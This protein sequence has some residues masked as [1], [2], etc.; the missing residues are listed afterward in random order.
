MGSYFCFNNV[1]VVA[2]W[3]IDWK[4]ARLEVEKPIE[5]GGWLLLEFWRCNGGYEYDEDRS[6]EV[7]FIDGIDKV[8]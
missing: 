4:E 3:R 1:S 6:G 2:G 5:K 8:C 7:Y